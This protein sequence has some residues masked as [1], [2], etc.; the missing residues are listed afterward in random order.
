M[1]RQFLSLFMFLGLMTTL[2]ASKVQA[3]I[4]G[5]LDADI[6]FQFYAGDTKFPPGK[7]II[8]PLDNTDLTVMEISTADGRNSA[9]FEVRDSQAGTSP[10]KTELIF[11]KY[12]NHYFLSKL[13][14]EGNKLGSA[15]EKSRYEKKLSSGSTREERHVSAHRR[16]Q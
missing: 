15:L 2:G 6:P 10:A 9:V 16:T 5:P 13:F 4:V 8:K 1:R 3:Q 7:Y 11:D 12:G 14:D